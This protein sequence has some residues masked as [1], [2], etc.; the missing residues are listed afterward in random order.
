MWQSSGSSLDR[1]HSHPWQPA[2][3]Q[4]LWHIPLQLHQ[5]SVHSAGQPVLCQRSM[6][7]LGVAVC[8]E[9]VQPSSL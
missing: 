7:W 3:L 4:Q 5:V 9:G 2:T 1:T 8:R 6:S